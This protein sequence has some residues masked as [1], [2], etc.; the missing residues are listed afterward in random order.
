LIQKGQ[1]EAVSL[2]IIIC[3]Q[4]R[5]TCAEFIAQ[6]ETITLFKLE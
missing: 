2:Y 5:R 3:V 6:L 4:D 1:S